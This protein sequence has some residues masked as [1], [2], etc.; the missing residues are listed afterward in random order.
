MEKRKN[1]KME[2]EKTKNRK[3]D[4]TIQPKCLDQKTF[5]RLGDNKYAATIVEC[6]LRSPRCALRTA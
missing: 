4:A 1:E 5:F 6:E 2:N 3:I